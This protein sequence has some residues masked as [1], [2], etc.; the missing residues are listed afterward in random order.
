MMETPPFMAV[1]ENASD[2]TGL[3]T[4]TA[5]RGNMTTAVLLA[6]INRYYNYLNYDALLETAKKEHAM[7]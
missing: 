6:C 5:G 3:R 4:R 7:T 2:G 1:H